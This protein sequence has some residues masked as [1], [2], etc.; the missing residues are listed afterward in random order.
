[1]FTSWRIKVG[2]I[3]V[4]GAGVQNFGGAG[5]QNWIEQ[6]QCGEIN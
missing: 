3:K 4:G 2:L 5:V 1:M 6:T